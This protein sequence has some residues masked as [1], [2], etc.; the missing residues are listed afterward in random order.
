MN[1]GGAKARALL[2]MEAMKSKVRQESTTSW[3]GEQDPVGLPNG[4]ADAA[5]ALQA[6]AKAEAR[7]QAGEDDAGDA[8]DAGLGLQG[9]GATNKWKGVASVAM[10]LQEQ[11]Q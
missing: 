8:G 4:I 3:R 10:P 11:G 5:V 9:L 2:Y 7:A 1:A 6:S